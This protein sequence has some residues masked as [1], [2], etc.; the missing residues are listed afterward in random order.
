MAAMATMAPYNGFL[1]SVP[2]KTVQLTSVPKQHLTLAHAKPWRAP[3]RVLLQPL[4]RLFVLFMS[5]RLLGLP[6]FHLV[7][8]RP[9]RP[10]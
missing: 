9:S 3:D 10:S 8:G 6:D 1:E 2:R 7:P 4:G 5:S